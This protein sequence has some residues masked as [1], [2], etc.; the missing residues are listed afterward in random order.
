MNE[1]K[2]SENAAI[3]SVYPDKRVLVVEDNAINLEVVRE[4]LKLAQIKVDTAADGEQAVRMVCERDAY[5]YDM[6]LMDV[7]MPRMD[8]HQATRAIRSC[9]ND[10]CRNLPIVAMTANAFAED[11]QAALEAG[12]N[13]HIA[14]PIDFKK[15]SVVLETYFS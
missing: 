15:L 4:I 12:M 1:D 2:Q 7:M 11:V 13:E 9:D 5:R 10:Y 8:G 14:K 3:S 6:V